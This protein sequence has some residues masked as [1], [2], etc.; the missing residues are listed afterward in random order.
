[1]LEFVVPFLLLVLALVLLVAEDVLPTGGALG[2]LAAGCLAFLLYLGFSNSLWTGCK[3][4]AL[5]VVLVPAGFWAWSTFMSNTRFGRVAFLQPPEAHEVD[6]S[7]QRA[8]LSRLIGLEGRALT[9]L[10]PS[11]MVDFDG[12]RLDGVAEEG[13][14]P[15][16]SPILAV[17]VHSGRLIVR[18]VPEA[19]S[20][21]TG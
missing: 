3:Y 14:I 13:L 12:R 21:G 11:G 17:R 9:T 4:L 7:A 6:S 15:L 16:G 20:E 18:P 2:L 5:E 19:R 8:D 10:R 1:M